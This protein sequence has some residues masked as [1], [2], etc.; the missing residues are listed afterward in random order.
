V[1]ATTPALRVHQRWA[2]RVDVPEMAAVEAAS[3]ARPWSEADFLAALRERQVIGMV[4]EADGRVAGFHLYELHH[5]HL[6]VLNFAVRPDCRRR[7]VGA[8]MADGLVRKLSAHR[9]T[10][11]GLMVG[12]WN[13]GAQLFWKAR[14][15]VCERVARRYYDETEEDGY[16]FAYRIA[17]SDT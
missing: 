5:E 4:A 9:R 11:V 7:G 6:F 15:F 12:E 10:A 16:E 1:T 13:L 17:G 2:V 3:F 14:G 8:Q